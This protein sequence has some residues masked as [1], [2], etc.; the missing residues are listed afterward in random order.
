MWLIL[1]Y[2]L[3]RRKF[4]EKKDIYLKQE[5]I[6]FIEQ[7]LAEDNIFEL[8]KGFFHWIRCEEKSRATTQIF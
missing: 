4:E 5:L 8:L 2:Y 3:Q 7:K 6:Q 1:N